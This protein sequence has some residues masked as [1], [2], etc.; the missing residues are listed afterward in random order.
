MKKEGE[1]Q[2]KPPEEE[3]KHLKGWIKRLASLDP[4]T[5]LLNRHGWVLFA[6]RHLKRGARDQKSFGILIAS[7]DNFTRLTD[8][9]GYDVGEEALQHV[10]ECIENQLRAGDLLGRW[11]EDQFILLLPCIAQEV[12]GSVAERIRN[13]VDSSPFM[14]GDRLL[15]LTISLGGG[16]KVVRTGDPKELD[17]LIA[18]ADTQLAQAKG[19]GPNRVVV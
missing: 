10:G 12:L 16:T 2:E 15:S 18:V 14:V 9:L 1:K 4:P 13:A 11:L 7:L 6:L 17:A 8:D 19:E 3:Y 5:G